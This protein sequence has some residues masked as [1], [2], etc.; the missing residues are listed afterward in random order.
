MAVRISAKNDAQDSSSFFHLK[1]SVFLSF[2]KSD[3]M[4]AE[5]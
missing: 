3:A 2:S 4:L 5:F 1:N